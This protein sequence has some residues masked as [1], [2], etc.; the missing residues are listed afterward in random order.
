MEHV[1]EEVMESCVSMRRK[2]ADIGKAL[3]KESCMREVIDS[4]MLKEME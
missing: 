2:D 1:R 4:I 3:W